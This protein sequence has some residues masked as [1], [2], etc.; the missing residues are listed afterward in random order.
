MTTKDL[1]RDYSLNQEQLEAII[2]KNEMPHRNGVGCLI[3]DDD[4][5][6]FLLELYYKEHDSELS[7]SIDNYKKAAPAGAVFHVDGARGRKIDIYPNKCVI[8]VGV[9]IGSVLTSNATDGEKTIYYCDCIGLQ[10][11]KPGV[12]LGYLQF[13]TAASTS[14]NLSSNFFNENTFTYEES[15]I[16]EH[17]M[18][19]IV[20]YA[21]DKAYNGLQGWVDCF[22]KAELKGY[23]FGKG[24]AEPGDAKNHTETLLDAYNLGKSL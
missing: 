5:L 14:N 10:F 18:D 24:I 2:L 12:T 13:E 17:C 20:E 8:T 15:H 6:D 21:I 4:N 1:A 22:E 9:T 11:K 7:F 3:V 23:V 16:N 19:T